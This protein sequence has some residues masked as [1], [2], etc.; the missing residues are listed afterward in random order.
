MQTA[1]ICWGGS[2]KSKKKRATGFKFLNF[3]TYFQ[4]SEA[5]AVVVPAVLLEV[6][7]GAVAVVEAA[8]VVAAVAVA[9][10]ETVSYLDEFE[11]PCETSRD[12]SPND[13][14]IFLLFETRASILFCKIPT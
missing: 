6:T 12:C 1:K 7:V 8:S 13:I 2:E 10:I 9:L 4:D 5:V 3:I 14:K 11:V